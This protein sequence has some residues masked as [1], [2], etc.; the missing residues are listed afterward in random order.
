MDLLSPAEIFKYSRTCRTARST[1]QSYMQR[2][3]SIDNLLSRYFKPQEVNRFREFQCH[4]GAII[5]GSTALQFLDRAVYP[6]SDLDLHVE[7]RFA[8]EMVEWLLVIG[9]TYAPLPESEN[10]RSLAE[11]FK[12]N[13]PSRPYVPDMFSGDI[14]FHSAGKDYFKAPF[15]FNF[16]K[17]HPFR[18]IQLITSL[19]APL[20]RILTFHSS[21]SPQSTCILPPYSLLLS[22]LWPV[23]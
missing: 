3:F 4:T 16:E 1:A 17:H 20:Q 21:M 13:P 5:S 15:V 18:K 22:P 2:A 7:H 19:Q 10:A 14:L 9:Y 6:E 12:R 8:H 23:S 11:A